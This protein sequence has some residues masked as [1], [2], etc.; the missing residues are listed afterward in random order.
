MATTSTQ[1]RVVNGNI[2]LKILHVCVHPKPREG[3][4]KRTS[5]SKAKGM[6][7]IPPQTANEAQSHAEHALSEP[8]PQHVSYLGPITSHSFGLQVSLENL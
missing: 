2:G 3:Q 6:L 8:S 4:A 1:G 5:P 7:I